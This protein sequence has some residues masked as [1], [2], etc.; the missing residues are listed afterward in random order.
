MLIARATGQCLLF[1]FEKEEGQ[2]QKPEGCLGAGWA[3]SSM[4]YYRACGEGTGKILI[5][6]GDTTAAG[7]VPRG[8]TSYQL[9]M[10]GN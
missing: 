8:G 4:V 6:R 7:E 2:G 3:S 10:G 9:E 5:S 1:I